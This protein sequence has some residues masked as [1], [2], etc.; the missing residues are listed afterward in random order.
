MVNRQ[1]ARGPARALFFGKRS[2]GVA[3]GAFSTESDP[4]K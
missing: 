2:V 4:A 1:E 3:F